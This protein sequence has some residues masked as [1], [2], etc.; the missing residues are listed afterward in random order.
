MTSALAGRG[1]QRHTSC[2]HPSS[3]LT[4]NPKLP[5]AGETLAPQC[6]VG[7]TPAPAAAWGSFH[8]CTDGIAIPGR[9][10]V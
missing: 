8:S 7:H 10:S 5:S 6:M 2:R 3:S 9:A 1:T 4:Q